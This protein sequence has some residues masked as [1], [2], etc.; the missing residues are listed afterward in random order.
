VGCAIHHDPEDRKQ[1]A[2]IANLRREEVAA[3]RKLL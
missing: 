1:F 3:H 2:S